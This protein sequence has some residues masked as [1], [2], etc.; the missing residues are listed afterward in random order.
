[1]LNERTVEALPLWTM[2][3]GGAPHP[4][5]QAAAIICA[6]VDDQ[7]LQTLRDRQE[8]PAVSRAFVDWY[9]RLVAAGAE[10]VIRRLN[11]GV[12]TLRPVVP[13]AAGILDQ[14]IV[15]TRPP[16]PVPA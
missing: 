9:R 11:G 10:K 16:Q 1:M 15:Q 13:T 8:E 6:T 7:P 12:E 2:A 14:V 3:A 5:I 4:R